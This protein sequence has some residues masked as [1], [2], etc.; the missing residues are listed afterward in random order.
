MGGRVR[1]GRIEAWLALVAPLT[2]AACGGTDDPAPSQ[3]SGAGSAMAGAG[4]DAGGGSAGAGGASVGGSAAGGAGAQGLPR[5]SIAATSHGT[6]ALDAEGSIHCWGLAPKVWPIPSGSFVELVGSSDS[7]CA[8]RADRSYECFSQPLGTSSE[9][10]Y[11]PQVKVQEVAIGR[12]I[13][14][15]IDEGGATSCGLYQPSFLSVPPATET[16]TSLSV[17]GYFACG[18]REGDASVHCW[19][20]T[21]LTSSECFDQGETEA[22]AGSFTSLASGTSTSCALDAAGALA[23]WGAGTA[24]DDPSELCDG[25]PMH[26]GQGTPPAGAF[27][28]VDVDYNHSCAIRADGTLACWG[29]GTTDACTLDVDWNC[30]QSLPPAGVFE[31]VAAGLSHSCAMT[32]DRKVACWGYDGDGDPAESGSGR[33]HPPELFQ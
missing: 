33:I 20:G 24:D 7:I 6:C 11:A 21:L 10:E 32:A 31:Q 4:A 13:I 15:V 1:S 18:L 25:E 22:P 26:F 27:K 8:I 16:F 17:G 12:G 14:C 3:G 28:H 2:V 23:C 19:A 30:R 9:L 5:G 29:A